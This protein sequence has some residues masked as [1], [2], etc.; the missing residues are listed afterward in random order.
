MLKYYLKV[1]IKKDNNMRI[2]HKDIN[3]DVVREAFKEPQTPFEVLQGIPQLPETSEL[4]TE[5]DQNSGDKLAHTKAYSFLNNQGDTAHLLVSVYGMESYKAGKIGLT[6]LTQE[7][8]FERELAHNAITHETKKYQPFVPESK[9][10][11]I[12]MLEKKSE[13]DILVQQA[14]LQIAQKQKE[15][16]EKEAEKKAQGKKEAFSWH[17][18]F[19]GV[20]L[21]KLV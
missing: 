9:R 19:F 18:L 14:Y 4:N 12:K 20:A 15:Q 2:E 5:W 3:Y 16:A 11:S 8:V 6:L 1:L 7:G 21:P 13:E 17:E 10:L